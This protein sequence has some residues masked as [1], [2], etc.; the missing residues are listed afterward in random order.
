MTEPHDAVGAALHRL[1][2][3]VRDLATGP[4]AA[5]LRARAD[6]RRRVRQLATATAAAGLVAAVAL[7]GNAVLRPLA[8][9][10]V[11]PPAA[12]TPTSTATP[13]GAPEPD[14]PR[15]TPSPRPAP[16]I[17]GRLDDP[18]VEVDWRRTTISIPPR[19]RCPDGP[20]EFVP[21]SDSF[22]TA[23]GPSG[24][25]PVVMID[26]SRAAYGDLTGDGRAE[27]VL[28]ARCATDEFGLASGHGIQLLVVT[29]QG[30]GTLV[31]L[32][33]IGPDGVNHLAWW[34]ADGRLLIDADPWTAAPEDHFPAVPGLAL[35]YEWDGS[36]FTGWRPAPE[37]PPIVPLVAGVPGPPVL[38]R[39][40][41]A[42]LGCPTEPIRF[43]RDQGWG[44]S[45]PGYVIPD[46]TFQPYLFDLDGT[47]NR[48]LVIALQCTRLDGASSWG[49]VVLERA[50][51]G[52]QGISALAAPAGLV[53]D[54][55]HL[56]DR[57]EMVVWWMSA[58]GGESHQLRYRWNGTE[59]EPVSE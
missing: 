3:E 17:P 45:A 39:A 55:W 31:G 54:S 20:V 23:L 37:Y 58:A 52:W 18:I 9:D 1:R 35:T 42:G 8:G 4:G 2:G 29:R 19:D 26:A 49:L 56:D 40:A 12:A 34:V 50:G 6:H 7:G 27:A 38:P 11:P 32:D 15:V 43:T 59:L 25:F 44:G 28:E 5:S 47:G 24:Q 22:P 14:L 30:D 10:S 21:V 16:Q 36:R 46:R 53:P 51:D 57:G 13:T 33:W 41:G 48:L